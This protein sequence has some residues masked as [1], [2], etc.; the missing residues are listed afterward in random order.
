VVRQGEKWIGAYATEAEARV[1]AE[2]QGFTVLSSRRKSS[3]TSENTQWFNEQISQ[4]R[5][6]GWTLGVNPSS[7]FGIFE[8]KFPIDTLLVYAADDSG[9]RWTWAFASGDGSS[10]SFDSPV[11]V[12]KYLEA[13]TYTTA[14]VKTA[15]IIHDPAYTDGFDAGSVGA[16]GDI[17]RE[18]PHDPGMPE[19]DSWRE[20]YEDGLDRNTVIPEPNAE[21]YPDVGWMFGS[22]GYQSST[23]GSRS[24]SYES[25]NKKHWK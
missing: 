2:E 9:D 8:R 24:A 1:A 23:L 22:E 13:S 21:D 12:A 16:W 3:K 6:L 20:G 5:G 7:V 25:N 14:S 18:N 11:E 17:D 15:D 10:D 4:M 19:Y